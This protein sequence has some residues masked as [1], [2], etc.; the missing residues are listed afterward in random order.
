MTNFLHWRKMTWTLVLWS[1][2][3]AT[4]TVITGSGPAIVTLWWLVGLAVFGPLSFAT[5]LFRQGRGLDGLFVWP[6]AD[7]LACRQPPPHPPRHGA[8]AR[9]RLERS[10]GARRP[11][12]RSTP[13]PTRSPPSSRAA[14]THP[15]DS[16]GRRSP[17]PTF[18][19]DAGTPRSTDRLRGL[20]A[21]RAVG[22]GSP[23]NPAGSNGA[24]CER[25]R[26]LQNWEDEGGATLSP[27]G[28]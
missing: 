23:R 21:L 20:Q 12:K 18:P 8:A 25:R 1:G 27:D 14:R 13:P 3:I 26:R 17:P 11:P 16:T 2:Y 15:R 22:T 19:D 5:R 9:C 24:G 6:G 4:W 10:G 7:G 28:P